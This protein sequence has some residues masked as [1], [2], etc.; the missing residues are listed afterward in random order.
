VISINRLTKLGL[1]C[2]QSYAIAHFIQHL[3]PV[4]AD[5]DDD[6]DGDDGGD[7][8]DDEVKAELLF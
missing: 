5:D 1:A 4:Q 6:G 8:G 3:L 2:E 7:D